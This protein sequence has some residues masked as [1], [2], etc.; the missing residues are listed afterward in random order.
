MHTYIYPTHQ[1]PQAYALHH[2]I[3]LCMRRL[4]TDV[5]CKLVTKCKCLLYAPACQ[6][7]TS[8]NA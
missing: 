4:N 1:L 3:V 8:C 6:C 2:K 7:Q 5:Y